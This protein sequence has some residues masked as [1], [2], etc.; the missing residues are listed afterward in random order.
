MNRPRFMYIDTLHNTLYSTCTIFTLSY[1]A[2]DVSSTRG[3]G[4]FMNR[5]RFA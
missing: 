1:V 4:G 3:A 2:H 5:A